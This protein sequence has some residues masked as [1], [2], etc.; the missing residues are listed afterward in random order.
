MIYAVSENSRALFGNFA[1]YGLTV[2]D[3]T[4]LFESHGFE[5]PGDLEPAER[6]QPRVRQYHDQ[7]DWEDQGQVRRVLRAYR[8]AIDEHGRPLAGRLTP[9][10]KNLLKSLERDGNLVYEGEI[11]IFE[12]ESELEGPLGAL[13]GWERI[14]HELTGLR[15]DFA[16]AV[17]PHDHQALA[18]RCLA[19]L[20]L[21]SDQLYEESM[22]PE[23]SD[24]PG[25]A[26]VKARIGQFVSAMAPGERFEHV[27]KLV[28]DAYAQAN[29]VKHRQSPDRVDSGVAVTATIL[30]AE[31]LRLISDLEPASRPTV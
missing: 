8:A 7:V 13:T 28:R 27:R 1:F 5:L 19:I 3:I 21:L 24:V 29:A 9:Q 6:R 10:A 18:L 31:M 12:P 22:C 25:V 23:G 16:V 11:L 14:D 20:R 2:A 4:R 17:E 26:D 15:R 30:L